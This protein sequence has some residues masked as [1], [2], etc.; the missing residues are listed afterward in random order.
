MVMSV[1]IL[2]LEH[3]SIRYMTGDFKDIGILEYLQRKVMGNYHVTEFWADRD[4]SFTL[5]KGDMLGI[6]G[7]NGA[8]KTTLLKA[9]SGI[10]PPTEGSVWKEGVMASLLELGS[11][12]D[13]NL[14]V[15]ENVYL[16]GAM[17]GYTRQ[18][19]NETYDQIIDYAELRDV[20]DRLFRHLSS[21]M[22]SRLAFSIA[23]LV[24]PDILILDEVLSVG[25]GA[26]RKKSEEKMKSIIAGGATTLLVSH[27][28]EQVRQMCSKVLWLHQGRQIA[29]GS[30]VQGI[31]DRY[32]RFLEHPGLGPDSAGGSLSAD[33]RAGLVRRPPQL[34]ADATPFTKGLV[35]VVT[36]VFNGEDHLPRMLDSVLRQTYDHMEMILVDDGSTDGTLA[37]AEGY[38]EKFAA[39]GYGYRVVSA[40]HTCASGAINQGLPFVTG[41]FLIWPD[42]D[43]VLEPSSVEAR[44]SFLRERPAYHCVR[45]LS[46]YFDAKT[47]KSGTSDEKT[48][49]LNRED[50]FWDMLEIRTFVS[51]GCYMLKSAD[52]FAIYPQRI[53]P[54][55]DVGQNFQML[56]PFLYYYR[57]PTLRQRLYGVCLRENSH[58]RRKLTQAQEVKKYL[59]YEHLVDDIAGICGIQ[60]QPSLDRIANWKRNRRKQLSRK[61][62]NKIRW[63]NNLRR[64]R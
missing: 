18:F 36:P 23:S 4:I 13:W 30:D 42:S 59:D 27:S 62:Q 34:P 44:V 38:R 7:V 26:F 51:C 50:L 64:G 14:T 15:R 31:C 58:S 49:D 33:L 60:D 32:V 54:Q 45:S 40:P 25:D 19:I 53:I 48:G 17:L 63:P 56:L 55:Y 46:Y 9:I 61:Y 11:G 5:E 41:E 43:D 2:K 6:I 37:V 39:R 21:G 16:R 24:N 52:F 47:G 12:F 1:D 28:M 20:Q 29:F 35:S 8:G 57:C 22:R 3:V 10:L